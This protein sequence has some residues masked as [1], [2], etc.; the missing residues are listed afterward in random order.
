[1]T[2]RRFRVSNFA[3]LVR[4]PVQIDP[5]DEYGEIGVRSFG[6]GIFHK[7]RVSG[8]E[9]G[10]KRVFFIAEGDLVVSNVFAWEGAVA[11]ATADEVGRIGS[12][13][14]MTWVAD[15]D[16]ADVRF[17]LHYFTSESG[18]EQLRRASPGSAGRNKTLAIKAFEGLL[19]PLPGVEEQ[20]AIAAKL[21][22]LSLATLHVA[23]AATHR[24][25]AEAL[26]R[27]RMIYGD[28]ASES[29]REVKLAELLV[30]TVDAVPLAGESLYPTAGI[31]NRGRGIFAGPVVTAESTKYRSLRRLHAGQVMYSKLKAFEGAISVVP[32][33]YDGFFTSHEFPTFEV[34]ERVVEVEYLR[35]VFLVKRFTELLAGSSKGLGARRERLSPEKFLSLSVPVPPTDVQRRIVRRIRDLGTVNELSARQKALAT[36][37]PLAARNEAFSKLL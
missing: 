6:R 14:F 20:R 15:P 22:E 32:E 8:A 12:H 2:V 34:Q 4:R 36:A 28:L 24:L 26:L 16:Q 25:E 29:T 11:V 18:L 27:E 17:L 13:R 35:N 37:L 30:E 5:A 33:Q 19:I 1:M 3:Q 31:R 9:I 10:D 7:P 21:D 23:D